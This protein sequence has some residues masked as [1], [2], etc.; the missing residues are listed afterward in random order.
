[1]SP[2]LVQLSGVVVDITYRV[3]AIPAPGHEAS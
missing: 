1:M 2:R 3:Q